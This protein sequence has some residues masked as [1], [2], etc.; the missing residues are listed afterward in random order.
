MEEGESD[1]TL[2]R[3]LTPED[4]EPETNLSDAETRLSLRLPSV[5]RL[6]RPPRSTGFPA[7]R[8]R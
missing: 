8:V 7:T 1:Q 5:V 2:A 4:G 3:R 6:F